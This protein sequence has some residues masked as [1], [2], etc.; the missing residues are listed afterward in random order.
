M[1][2][3]FL[4]ASVLLV[5][6]LGYL[7]SSSLTAST[8]KAVPVK[9]LRAADAKPNS[10]VGQKLRAVG[11]VGSA[12]PKNTLENT[13]K[14]AVKTVHFEVV[15]GDAKL[16]V[17]YANTLPD[18]FRAGGPVQVDGTYTEAGKI[19][20]DHVLTKCPSKYEEGEAAKKKEGYDSKKTQ[21]AKNS[22]TNAT[23]ANAMG[24]NA[25]GQSRS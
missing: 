9:E 3:K 20:A 7:V 19:R 11:F 12:K 23:N 5:A 14:G 22:G 10:F 6:S 8:M 1:Q 24:A 4:A 16:L 13:E 21:S 15:E 18:T 17:S 2:K 25:Q